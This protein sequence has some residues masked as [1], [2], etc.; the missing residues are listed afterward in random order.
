MGSYFSKSVVQPE[1]QERSKYQG[2]SNVDYI[3]KNNSKEKL[4]APKDF[5]KKVHSGKIV[6]GEP[7]KDSF[8]HLEHMGREEITKTNNVALSSE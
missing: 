2:M 1:T 5:R 8:V 3:K 7:V 6:I 4:N